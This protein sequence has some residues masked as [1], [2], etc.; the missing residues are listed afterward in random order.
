M[1]AMKELCH[2][3]KENECKRGNP[4]PPPHRLARERLNDP[5]TAIPNRC[6]RMSTLSSS[7][8]PSMV[9]SGGEKITTDSRRRRRSTTTTQKKKNRIGFSLSVFICLFARMIGPCGS[10]HKLIKS[11]SLLYFKIML[12]SLCLLC[13]CFGFVIL[14]NHPSLGSF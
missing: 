11:G 14:S 7:P 10:R 5:V 9:Q 2:H 13:V 12:F 3:R 1:A 6:R 8:S 4:P